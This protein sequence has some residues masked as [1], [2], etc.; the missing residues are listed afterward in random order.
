MPLRQFKQLWTFGGACFSIPYADEK[1]CIAR[2]S[3]EFPVI[4]LNVSN[5]H[6]AGVTH[7][8]ES[9]EIQKSLDFLFAKQ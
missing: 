5:G 6:L 1:I 3:Q 9:V 7:G 2:R 8:L 4:G